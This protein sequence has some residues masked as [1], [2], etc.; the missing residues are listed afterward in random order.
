MVGG[1]ATIA[2]GVMAVYVGLL[3]DL[4]PDIAGHLL[5]ASIMSAP[6]ALA[7]AKIAIPETGEPVTSGVTPV[8]HEKVDVNIVDA[9]SR[10]TTEGLKL[11]LNVGA[12]LIAFLALVAM[13]NFGLK[14]FGEYVLRW[15]EGQ[16]LS[17]Q[18]ILGKVFRY[19]AWL[20]GV[21]W[22]DSDAVGQLLG[23]KMITN[24]L[25]AYLG[26]QGLSS[27]EAL[28][29]HS[30]IIASYALCGFSNLGSIGIMIGGIGAL[31]PSRRHDLARLAPRAML[32]A[33]LASYMTATIAGMLVG[34]S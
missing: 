30:E 28:S 23:T 14:L 15:P 33:T 11:A 31:C 34:G 20:I 27:A 21:S 26:L 8:Q 25:V 5:A 7:F 10:G 22:Q 3:K 12:M 32:A 6:A 29:G 9:A 4:I 13:V 2:G 16:D 18:F 24:E 19:V 17:M 1:F